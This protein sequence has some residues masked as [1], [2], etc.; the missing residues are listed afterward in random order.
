[1]WTT[2]FSSELRPQIRKLCVR[3]T[4][5]S[6]NLPLESSIIVDINDAMST[7]CQTGLY[8]LIVLVQIRRIE[9][10]GS[11]PGPSAIPG[12]GRESS[13]VDEELPADRYVSIQSA[14]VKLAWK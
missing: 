9:L 6:N 3:W 4:A 7:C 12:A 5:L 13:T 8:E 10:S 14:N 11:V 1:M 2:N